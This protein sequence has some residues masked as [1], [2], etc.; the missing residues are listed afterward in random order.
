M[1]T[2]SA[3]RKKQLLAD[4]AIGKAFAGEV[5]NLEFLGRQLLSN[6]GGPD[7]A[8]FTCSSK[9]IASAIGPRRRPEGVE[10]VTRSA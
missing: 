2:H 9:L 5:C 8:R 4:L 7:M 6:T 1:G 3:V 10:G